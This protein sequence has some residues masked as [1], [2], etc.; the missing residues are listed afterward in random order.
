[1]RLLALWVAKTY[2]AGFKGAHRDALIGLGTAPLDD[3]Q[4]RAALFEQLGE[5]R[6]EAAVTTD[7]CG[8]KDSHAVRLDS[9]ATEEMSKGRVHRKVATSIFFESNGGIVKAEASAPEIRL[10]VAE[11]DMDIGNIETALE[12]LADSCYYLTV[13][14]NRYHFSF[15]EN[16]NKRYAD[17]RANIKPETIDE[18][19]RGEVAKVFSGQS[20]VERVFFPERSNQ[21]PDRAVLS[22]IVLSPEKSLEDEKKTRALVETIVR[23]S[24]TSGRTFKSALLF[25]VPQAPAQ[26]RED[27][28]RLLAWEEIQTELPGISVD[29]AQRNQLVDN[30]KKAQRDL[31]EAV[32]RTYKN[33]MLLGKDNQ[34]QTIDLG[35]AHSSAAES[36]VQFIVNQLR[37]ADEIQTSISPGFLVRNWSPAFKEWSTRS[38]RDAFY[39]SPVFPRLLNAE[40]I[41]QT[42]VRGIQDGLLG[43]VSKG[44]DGKYITFAFERS[45]ETQDIEI[46]DETFIITKETAL[47]YREAQTK[48]TPDLPIGVGD[49]PPG[50]S[51]VPEPDSLSAA[52]TQS[53]AKS[54]PVAGGLRS[55]RWSGEIPSQKWMNFYTRVLSKFATGSGLR[56][57][58]KVEIAPEGGVSE[59]KVEETRSALRELGL[60]DT[61][62]KDT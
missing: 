41:K 62:D 45:L 32:W 19:V 46:S 28:R 30:L 3:P 8:K 59:Q 22:L 17:R 38:I 37:Q 27:A 55:L 49:R 4:F 15:R 56:L 11:P 6:L 7:I 10:D 42:I 1:L 16:L 31:K 48:P 58:V 26:I 2:Q 54:K 5:H 51:G 18:H 53:L 25:A 50:T 47:A 20:P 9:E 24:G 57:T 36:L 12:A 29:D 43:Y 39:A 14:R 61:L 33:I 21:V 23:E 35:L 34:I 13:E 44:A 60:N 40:S 52:Q